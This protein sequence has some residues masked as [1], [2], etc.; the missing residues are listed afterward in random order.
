MEKTIAWE[1]ALIRMGFVFEKRGESLTF[2]GESRENFQLLQRMLESLGVLGSLDGG[3]FTPPVPAVDEEQWISAFYK[4]RGSRED[5][6]GEVHRIMLHSLDPY[7][8]GIVRW[9]AAI[10]IRTAMSCDGHGKRLA[11]L[12]FNRGEERYAAI[13]E[14]CLAL[15][16]NGRWQFRYQYP[17]RSGHL[18]IRP[19]LQARRDSMPGRERSFEQGWLLD[20]AE[21]LYRHQGVLRELAASMQSVPGDNV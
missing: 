7:I 14:A 6:P 19:S 5:F 1:R 9:C 21:A 16:S 20:V 15:I 3:I 10:G 12:Y 8:A 11:S 17:G 13:L 2:L 4:N 18:T